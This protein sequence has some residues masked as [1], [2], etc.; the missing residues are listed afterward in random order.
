MIWKKNK[1]ERVRE[2]ESDINWQ[3]TMYQALNTWFLQLFFEV[4]TSI[5]QDGEMRKQ[6]QRG[7]FYR[8]TYWTSDKYGTYNE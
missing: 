5:F 6:A 8:V 4:D 1:Q 2:I 3:H 7:H